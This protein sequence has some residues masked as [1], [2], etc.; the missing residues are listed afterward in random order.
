[1]FNIVILDDL[2]YMYLSSVLGVGGGMIYIA[3]FVCVSV[4]FESMRPLATSISSC[5]SSIGTFVF[6]FLYRVCIDHYGWRGTLIVF[7]GLMLNGI[8]CGTLFRPFA[9][10]NHLD[11][12]GS[13]VLTESGCLE[14]ATGLEK[15]NLK[16]NFNTEQEQ[17]KIHRQTQ[18]HIHPYSDETDIPQD[19]DSLLCSQLDPTSHIC[20]DSSAYD[21]NIHFKQMVL[22][23]R[24]S[25]TNRSLNKTVKMNS[26]NICSKHVVS[27]TE[28]KFGAKKIASLILGTTNL[29]MFKDVG[30][31][32]YGVSTFL[33]CF[34]LGIP[35]VL[36]P[37][38]AEMNGKRAF[39][40]I[41]TQQMSWLSICEVAKNS[42]C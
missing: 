41:K 1:M 18:N 5:G 38:M 35:Y 19:Q 15:Q 14:T 17:Y 9:K 8:V 29:S 23:N 10:E 6:G 34:G 31:V 20:K 30:F 21:E 11:V 32:L 39:K 4:Y 37:D 13:I 24:D 16:T 22:A 26:S 40:Q 3:C 42:D 25:Q 2:P 36:L 7:A 12:S 33:F 28:H 27:D